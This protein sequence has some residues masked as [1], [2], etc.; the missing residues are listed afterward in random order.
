MESGS[1]FWANARGSILELEAALILAF[2]LGYLTREQLG[3]IGE[4]I[5]SVI[6]ADQRFAESKYRRISE[7]EVRR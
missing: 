4:R 2:D 7:E 1:S 6:N 3:P 5:K